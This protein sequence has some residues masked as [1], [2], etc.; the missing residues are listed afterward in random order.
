[1][2]IDVAGVKRIGGEWSRR[3]PGAAGGT[4]MITLSGWRICIPVWPIEWPRFQLATP[5]EIGYR[6]TELKTVCSRRIALARQQFHLKKTFVR[7]LL[8]SIVRIGM[9]VLIFRESTRSGGGA[10]FAEPFIRTSR[11]P[12]VNHNT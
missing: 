11:G 4:Q 2:S 8:N 3:R 10:V 9:E 7:C 6:K 5:Q 12:Y 1:M